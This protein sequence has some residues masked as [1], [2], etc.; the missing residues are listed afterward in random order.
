M[1]VQFGLLGYT[2]VFGFRMALGCLCV[3]AGT[4]VNNW[5]CGGLRIEVCGPEQLTIAVVVM[6]NYNGCVVRFAS[7]F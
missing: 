5:G 4:I 6:F 7:K 3:W 1:V 2:G